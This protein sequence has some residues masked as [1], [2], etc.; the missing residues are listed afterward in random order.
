MKPAAKPKDCDSI[1]EI[2]G[3][4]DIIDK[5]IIQLLA[6]RHDYVKEIVKFKSGDEKSI[7]ASERKELVFKQ[8]RAWAI[9]RGLDGEMIEE[10]FRLLIKQ[11]IQIQFDIQK[12]NNK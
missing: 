7:V 1:S 3:A 8:R 6:Q 5:E 9:E 11:N 4:I 10:I 12:S 2:R